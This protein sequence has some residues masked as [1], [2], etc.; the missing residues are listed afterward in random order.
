LVAAAE[1]AP[2]LVGFAARTLGIDG[3]AIGPAEVG[4]LATR[5]REALAGNRASTLYTF[6]DDRGRLRVLASAPG[7]HHRSLADRLA[8]LAFASLGS[9]LPAP[10]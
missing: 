6:L 4:A 1:L 5:M 9:A 2:G 10:E 8:A 7:R 3:E